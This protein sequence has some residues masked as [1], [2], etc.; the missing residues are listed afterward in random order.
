MELGAI[1]GV[2]AYTSLEACH[3]DDNDALLLPVFKLLLLPYAL[4][5]HDEE[6]PKL[7]PLLPNFE[8]IEPGVLV[9]LWK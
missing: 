3:D 1:G 8:A 2:S 5:D 4:F 7:P 6:W 9:L